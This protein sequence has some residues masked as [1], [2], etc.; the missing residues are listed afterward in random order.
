MNYRNFASQPPAY[1][2][3]GSLRAEDLKSAIN[4]DG[5]FYPQRIFMEC[6]NNDCSGK[7]NAS[8][9]MNGSGRTAGDY[10]NMGF[11]LLTNYQQNQQTQSA[12]ELQN[13]QNEAERLRLQQEK[14]RLEQEQNKSSIIKSYGLPIAIGGGIIIIGIATYFIFKKKSK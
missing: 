3:G 1:L 2:Y 6:P 7:M 11:G 8:G 10:I 12:I 4:P 14:I 13:Q 5:G 9:K